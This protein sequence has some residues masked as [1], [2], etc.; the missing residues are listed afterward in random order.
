MQVATEW[1][2]T[3]V[4][5]MLRRYL[6]AGNKTHWTNESTLRLWVDGIVWPVHK[7]D[8]EKRGADPAIAKSI[9]NI[10]CY[11]VHISKSLRAWLKNKYSQFCLVY[12]PPKCTPKAQFADVV[13]NKPFKN[14]YSH[15]HSLFLMR[16]VKDHLARNKELATFNFSLWPQLW[17]R[18]HSSGW[19]RGTTS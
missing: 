10:D 12:V 13:L 16:Q 7:K 2:H 18:P 14:Y 15:A 6:P 9:I 19:Y 1:S 11:P 8:C 4:G 5:V 17:L 3:H